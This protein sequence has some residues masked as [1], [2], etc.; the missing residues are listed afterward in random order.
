M[1]FLNEVT[2]FA[3]KDWSYPLAAQ[4][5]SAFEKAA[6][7]VASC[8]SMATQPSA[9]SAVHDEVHDVASNSNIESMMHT[10]EKALMQALAP[11]RVKI[12]PAVNGYLKQ[13]HAVTTLCLPNSIPNNPDST[14]D[15]LKCEVSLPLDHAV[16]HFHLT[17]VSTAIARLTNLTDLNVDYNPICLL[18]EAAASALVTCLSALSRIQRLSICGC[19]LTVA[20]F[21]KLHSEVFKS[22]SGLFDLRLSF[23]T[24][25]GRSE[26]TRTLPRD[27]PR[28]R[29]LKLASVMMNVED[30]TAVIACAVECCSQMSCLDI[31][32]NGIPPFQVIYKAQDK[33]E[34]LLY[35]VV[36]QTGKPSKFPPPFSA[37]HDHHP[38]ATA[39]KF[40]MDKIRS[41]Y[42]SMRS[43]IEHVDKISPSCEALV[44]DGAHLKHDSFSSK[45]LMVVA[46]FTPLRTLLASRLTTLVL[47]NM[48]IG[49]GLSHAVAAHL[50]QLTHLVHF[51]YYGNYAGTEGLYSICRA[52]SYT[53]CLQH[54]DLGCNYVN[55]ESVHFVVHAVSSLTLLRSLHLAAPPDLTPIEHRATIT[56]GDAGLHVLCKGITASIV[57]TNI[58]KLNLE[59]AGAGAAGM[60][61]I[62]NCIS[63]MR[64]LVYLNIS[65]NSVTPHCA[66]ALGA[67]LG[68]LQKMVALKMEGCF[69]AV[70][71]TQDMCL[72][73]LSCIYSMPLLRSFSCGFNLEEVDMRVMLGSVPYQTTTELSLGLPLPREYA[74]CCSHHLHRCCFSH[75]FRYISGRLPAYQNLQSL[76]WCI[77]SLSEKQQ[78]SFSKSVVSLLSNRLAV[79]TLFCDHPCD[80]SGVASDAEIKKF[81]EVSSFSIKGIITAAAAHLSTVKEL[82]FIRLS[83]HPPCVQS[84][85]DAPYQLQ[86]MLKFHCEF[87]CRL[88]AVKTSISDVARLSTRLHA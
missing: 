12:G 40:D 2:T 53:P 44:L 50:T 47:R 34:Q 72:S 75:C 64:S 16:S 66:V 45:K 35:G 42:S 57:H 22:H 7:A 83:I 63:N 4:S 77:T 81:R 3:A 11:A 87:R 59:G 85:I 13:L 31:T 25:L 65:H 76:T 56:L 60:D 46:A 33:I 54:L 69:D 18:G 1:P 70:L 30:T 8:L 80:V 21:E 24:E 20:C 10:A 26:V 67:A 43:H 37:T 41:A 23:N 68:R 79:L 73:L 15:C 71:G 55:A 48:D 51:D 6:A 52:L 74:V 86:R 82:N 38:F 58:S 84:L 32:S 29:T 9:A 36:H 27:L 39:I 28:L 61:A 14:T 19:S 17:R 62:A 49:P 88:V 78:T 5:H